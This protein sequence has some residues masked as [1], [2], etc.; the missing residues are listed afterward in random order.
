MFTE[1]LKIAELISGKAGRNLISL[2]PVLFLSS[3]D[4]FLIHKVIMHGV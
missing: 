3:R 2:M 1:L 4:I